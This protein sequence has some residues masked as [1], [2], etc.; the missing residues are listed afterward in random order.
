M[1]HYEFSQ[2]SMFTILEHQNFSPATV[3]VLKKHSG[4][5]ICSAFSSSANPGEDWTQ[6][7]DLAD[8]RRVQNRI[9]QRS[10]RKKLK[11]RIEDLERRAGREVMTTMDSLTQPMRLERQ[12]HV[13][14]KSP[15]TSMAIK[16]MNQSQQVILTDTDDETL[17]AQYQ[18]ENRER[19]NFAP[20]LTY[21]TNSA[22][23]TMIFAPSYTTQPYLA[24]AEMDL[25]LTEHF[26]DAINLEESLSYEWPPSLHGF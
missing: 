12:S 15:K 5:G 16:S 4:H 11:R 6:I 8:R 23:E 2:M 10:Y 21:A 20:L 13:A 9:A 26:N 3:P 25:V 18:N 24:T 1:A 22:P 14:K 17:F 19:S 7:S